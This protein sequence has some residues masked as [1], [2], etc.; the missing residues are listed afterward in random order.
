MSNKIENILKEFIELADSKILQLQATSMYTPVTKDTCF[1]NIEK[2][3]SL[4]KDAEKIL[5][6]IKNNKQNE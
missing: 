3:E 4:I 1:K 2:Y 6:K 5:K